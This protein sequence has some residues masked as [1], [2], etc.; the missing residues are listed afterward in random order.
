[1]TTSQG[2]ATPRGTAP[3]DLVYLYKAAGDGDEL[4]YS[5]RSLCTNADGL[6]GNVWVSGE[7]PDWADRVGHIPAGSVAGRNE[8]VRAK[9]TAA[10]SHPDVAPVFLLVDDDMFLCRK[11]AGFESFHMGPT[12]EFL[13][14]RAGDTHRAWLRR[15][16]ATA[17]WMAEQGYGDILVRQGHKPCL[18]GKAA[19]AEALSKYPKGHPLDVR[20]LY[21]AAGAVGGEGRRAGNTKVTTAAQFHQKVKAL[22]DCPWLSS[23][24]QQFAE[25]LIGGY[26]RALFPDPCRFEKEA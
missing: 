23:S 1:M 25:G 3:P 19:L 24:D 10:A 2:G 21:D 14:K 5:L 6:F 26:V 8:D 17:E 16:K 11:V 15:I 9:L 12:S 4:R 20:G 18:Y 7:L 13:R 22:D